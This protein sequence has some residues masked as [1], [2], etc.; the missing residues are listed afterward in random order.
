MIAQAPTVSVV[1]GS[2]NAEPWIHKTLDSILTQTRPV[3]EVLIV[4]DGSTDSTPEIVKSY[5][6]KVKYI[7]EKHRGRP[8]RNRGIAGSQGDFIAF[9]DADDYWHPQKL[10][11]QMELLL[12]RR[13]AWAIC[14][15]QWSDFDTSQPLDSRNPP[16]QDGDVLEGLFLNNFIASATPVVAK[17]VFDKVGYFD[18]SPEVRVVEDWDLWLRIAARFPLGCVRETLATVRLHRGSFLAMT[19]LADRVRSL[20]AVVARAVDREPAR[21]KRL[22][23]RALANIYYSAGVQAIRATR[24]REARAYFVRELKFRP[25]HWEGAGY[26]VLTLLE[27]TVARPILQFKRYLWKIV[28]GLR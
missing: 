12:F 23:S 22:R 27:S 6:S 19:P 16:I 25:S 11:L 20:E 7:Q 5:G 26:V 2:Y 10:E 1:I 28:G 21:L 9:I 24:F 3:L 15:A 4:D 14:Q 18:E 13:L 8:H 17:S